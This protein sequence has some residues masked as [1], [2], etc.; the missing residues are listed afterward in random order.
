MGKWGIKI[1]THLWHFK[2]HLYFL[3]VDIISYPQF[4][5]MFNDYFFSLKSMEISGQIYCFMYMNMSI[6]VFILHA[7]KIEKPEFL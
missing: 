2:I 7:C 5:L 4:V 1:E 6:K 3:F